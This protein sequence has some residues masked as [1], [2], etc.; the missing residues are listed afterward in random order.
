MSKKKESPKGVTL[1]FPSRGCSPGSCS[2]LIRLAKVVTAEAVNRARMQVMD[3]FFSMTLA[4]FK[5]AKTE[6]KENLKIREIRNLAV[7]LPAKGSFSNFFSRW[8]EGQEFGTPLLIESTSVL[9]LNLHIKNVLDEL[10]V[11]TLRELIN[12]SESQLKRRGFGRT[13][14]NEVKSRLKRFGLSLAAD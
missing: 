3:G 12:F 5:K 10:N 1:P 4:Q 9:G 7:K 8:E 6:Y 13:C 11:K 14:L 2:P